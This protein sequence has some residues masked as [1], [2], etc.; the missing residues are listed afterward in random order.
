MAIILLRHAKAGDREQWTADD[1]LR[2]LTKPGLRQAD[3]LVEALRTFRV[4]SVFSSPFVRCVETV[5]PLAK[6]RG[7]PVEET[8]V[9]AEGAGAKDAIIL[10]RE[11]EDDAVLCTH[12]DVL[13]YVLHALTKKQTATPKGGG[14]VIEVGERGPRVI[15]AL[16]PPGPA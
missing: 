10:M 1:R 2:P 13:W 16:H 4:A 9:L 8:A 6:E 15:R 7:L 11:L 14:W 12:G 5:K 3:G